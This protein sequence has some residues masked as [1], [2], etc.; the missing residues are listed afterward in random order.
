[1]MFAKSP[2][3]YYSFQ[4]FY[5]GHPRRILQRLWL[6]YDETHQYLDNVTEQ[7]GYA[8]ERPEDASGRPVAES[9]VDDLSSKPWKVFDDAQKESYRATGLMVSSSNQPSACVLST[10]PDA[11]RP[12]LSPQQRQACSRYNL[13]FPT[14]VTT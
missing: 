11:E 10:T 7:P 4:I 9:G 8:S 2:L 14:A 13:T 12:P 5:V 3:L 1:M 6:A